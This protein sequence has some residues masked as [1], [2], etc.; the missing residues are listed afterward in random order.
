MMNAPTKELP[1]NIVGGN[2]FG[3][4]AKISTEETI[5]MM[6]SDVGLVPMWGYRKVLNIGGEGR[7]LYASTQYNH[8]IAVVDDVAYAVSA[9]NS[10]SELLR[11]QTDSGDVFISENDGS[12]IAI[13]DGQTIYAFNYQTNTPQSVV[14]VDF[15]PS[16]LDFQDG[17]FISCGINTSGTLP[18]YNQWRLSS[19]NNG[20]LWTASSSNVGVLQSKPDTCVAT[21]N[22]NKKIYLFGKKVTE[23]WSDIGYTLFPYQRDNYFNIDY[24]CINPATI[25]TGSIQYN[26]GQQLIPLICW[27]GINEKAGPTIM[28]STGGPPVA[29]STD[30]INF[31]IEQLTNPQDCYGFIFRLAGHTFYQ[32]VW[33]TDN[34]SY[35]IDFNVNKFFTV[36]DENLNYHIAKRVAFFNNKYYFLSV[37]DGNLYEM[38]S[39]LPTYDYT[40]PGSSDTNI[41]EIP[42]IR[43]PAPIRANN[44]EPFIANYIDLTMEQGNSGTLQRVDMTLSEDG[45]ISY[46][47]VVSEDLNALG[48]RQNKFRIWDLGMAN[49]LRI[50]FRFWGFERFVITDGVIGVYQ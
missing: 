37:N 18:I 23:S 46:G 25:A 34:I 41:K 31:K 2:Q 48:N 12:Q 14:G 35:A 21:V 1:L 16:Y 5:N 50:Q 33:P 27:L 28:Y 26:D 39:D 44:S 20:A 7:G 42:R 15:L 47:N 6:M 3:R 22:F 19:P 24:G 49:D 13:A 10:K 4:Y 45:G 29:L 38:A 32:I 30:G 9:D 8:L 11:L 36:T 17:Y 43:I 40:D